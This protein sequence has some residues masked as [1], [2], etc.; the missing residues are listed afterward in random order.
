MTATAADT[1]AFLETLSVG[2]RFWYW[3][4][5]AV[6]DGHPMLLA[7]PM[8]AQG[9]A[10]LEQY[11]R[12]IPIVRGGIPIIGLGNVA[13]A[14]H[15]QLSSPLAS[16]E[17]L[18][19]LSAWVRAEVQEHAGLARLK[20]AQFINIINRVVQA[21]HQDPALWEGVPDTI[22]PGSLDE[23]IMRLQKV[24]PERSY[25]FCLAES[26]PGDKPFLNLQSHRRDPE[27]TAFAE[28][29]QQM[30]RKA[31]R[32]GTEVRGILRKSKQGS[33]VFATPDALEG[34]LAI[35]NRLAAGN[36]V[37]KDLLDQA[38]LM[39][40]MG[41]RVVLFQASPR[42]DLS[43]QSTVLNGLKD[44]GDQSYFWMYE[45]ENTTH[46]QLFSDRDTFR[47][48]SQTIKVTGK[49]IKGRVVVSRSG[50]LE[51]RTRSPY[52]NFVDQ[53]IHWATEHHAQWPALRRLHDARMTQRDKENNILDRQKNS[54]AWSQLFQ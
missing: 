48:L 45:A 1:A 22:V 3:L 18:S 53:L 7:Q 13:D 27:G 35:M 16:A 23:T 37:L 20:N 29:L 32:S 47:A 30:R 38:L 12:Q 51:F 33:L 46:L 26:G 40:S 39:S 19:A 14:G 8:S 43:E 28:N 54:E 50:W 4:C 5:V 49:N 21:V 10:A 17:T 25:W 9:K 36:D 34:G 11:G 31:S 42:L 2:D 52:P 15:I 24:P 6:E 41:S 44:Q